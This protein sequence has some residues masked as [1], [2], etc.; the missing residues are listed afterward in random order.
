MLCEAEQ[1][2]LRPVASSW[3]PLEVLRQQKP[4]FAT[5]AAT[6][7]ANPGGKDIMCGWALPYTSPAALQK[8]TRRNILIEKKSLPH[9]LV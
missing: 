1:E 2:E 9:L 4:Y 6:L 5:T 7:C 8:P 3:L